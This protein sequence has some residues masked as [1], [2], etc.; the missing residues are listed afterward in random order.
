MF[1]RPTCGRKPFDLFIDG[2]RLD[3]KRAVHE[4][5]QQARVRFEQ[6]DPS[7]R[8]EDAMKFDQR[9]ARVFQ[10]MKHIGRDQV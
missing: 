2:N 5:S 9:G 8:A 1:G 6:D 3:V 7:A 4:Q 10:V